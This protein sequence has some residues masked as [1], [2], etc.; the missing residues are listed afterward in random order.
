MIVDGGGKVGKTKKAV[1]IVIVALTALA[2]TSCLPWG[3]PSGSILK[4]SLVAANGGSSVLGAQVNVYE[5]ST[6]NLIGKSKSDENGIAKVTLSREVEY[7]DVYFTGLECAISKISGLKVEYVTGETV[8]VILRKAILELDQPISYAPEVS[9][10]FVDLSGQTLPDRSVSSYFKAHI[11]V[12]GANQIKVLYA[13]LGEVPGSGRLT[14]EKQTAIDTSE[15]TFEFDPAG[16]NGVVPFHVVVYD[17]NDNRT[18]HIEYLNLSTQREAVNLYQ[19]LPFTFLRELWGD[20]PTFKNLFCYTGS[21]DGISYYRE[22]N[23]YSVKVAPDNYEPGAAPG[24]GTLWIDIQWLDHSSYSSF[25]IGEQE[26]FERPDGYNIYRS[27]DGANYKKIAFV[28]QTQTDW[29]SIG[30]YTDKSALLEPQKEVWYR[31]SS[32]YGT[33]ES[34]PTDLGSVVPLE[35][36]QVVQTSPAD[37]ATEVSRNPSFIWK[38]SREILSSE[39]EVTYRYFMEITDFV[40]SDIEILPGTVDE[41]NYFRPYEF[42]TADPGPVEVKFFGNVDLPLDYD[43]FI[44]SGGIYPY[45]YDKLEAN[46]TYE[47]VVASAGAYVIDDD[48]ASYSVAT[49]SFMDGPEVPLTGFKV[50]TTGE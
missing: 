17:H 31:V 44:F 24:S 4:F 20:E 41:F 21:V 23:P 25:E 15:V 11:T 16:Y 37:A 9:V 1:P 13:D 46:K 22:E 35:A 43:W 39:G 26:E 38:P 49:G 40:Q 8:E 18:D 12:T 42:V 33:L 2:L 30:A 6:T 32:V 34:T 10:E 28:S 45:Q 50:F 19:P 3:M 36:F 47:W 48:S 14:P 29:N 7:V 5:H 27:F